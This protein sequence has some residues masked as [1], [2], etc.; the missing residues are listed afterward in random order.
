MNDES[1]LTEGIYIPRALISAAQAV[2]L[3]RRMLLDIGE[4][5]YEDR[6][7][8]FIN[9]SE[10]T[11]YIAVSIARQGKLEQI[12]P[13]KDIFLLSLFSNIGSYRFILPN[14]T[15][16]INNTAERDYTY[17]YYF[18]KYMSPFG[19]NTKFLLF[20]NSKYNPLLA[21]KVIQ[22]EYAHLIF[23]AANVEAYLRRNGYLYTSEDIGAL[24][25]AGSGSNYAKLF[26]EA[27][28]Q[29]NIV[30]SIRMIRTF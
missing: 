16:S 3:I 17:S 19:A 29:L 21:Q 20:H 6:H 18:L 28:R 1:A 11:A 30:N 8:P 27:D 24:D 13:L 23:F 25:Q 12:M 4:N 22:A 15:S 5:I 2:I 14:F 26:L 10:R 9:E 7:M